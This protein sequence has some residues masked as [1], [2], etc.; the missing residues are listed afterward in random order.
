MISD[1]CGVPVC[2]HKRIHLSVRMHISETTLPNFTKFYLLVLPVAV[3]RS[4]SL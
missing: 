3:A 4:S 2:M 1:V